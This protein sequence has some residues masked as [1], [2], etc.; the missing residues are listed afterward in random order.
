MQ[1]TL[2]IFA[3]AVISLSSVAFA[4]DNPD[5]PYEGFNR[6]MWSFNK[7]VD[8]AMKPI[9]QAYSDY[10]PTPIISGIG[11]F[12]GNIGELPTAINLILQWEI[13]KASNTLGRFAVNSTFGLL[14]LF[15]VATEMEIER[16]DADFGG[17]LAS[18]GVGE[19]GYL[20]LPLLGPST[21]RDAGGKAVD[22]AI[23][24]VP[25]LSPVDHRNIALG[26]R[27]I[28]DR[29]SLL[30]ADKLVEDAAL[31]EYSYVRSAWLQKRRHDTNTKRPDTE[32]KLPDEESTKD[33]P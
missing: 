19:G 32:E 29:S 14:G 31:D 20:V 30:P 11:N 25:S 24:P 13:P 3:A 17:T 26:T 27:A 2:P 18:W 16:S 33:V 1:K 28:H 23:D 15:D 12:F 4:Q 7:T 9:A 10:V 21:L 5:D 6:A 22:I 8:K